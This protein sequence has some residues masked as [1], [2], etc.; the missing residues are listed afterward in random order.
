M[1][2]VL[3]IV[4]YCTLVI[5]LGLTMLAR[6]PLIQKFFTKFVDPV[7]ILT[8]G[9]RDITNFEWRECIVSLIIGAC[10]FSL[11]QNYN[12][13]KILEKGIEIFTQLMEV[14]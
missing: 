13:L 11:L 1:F 7:K 9:K 10:T 3:P 5:L 4:G 6:Y 2:E 14:I 8:F 12:I